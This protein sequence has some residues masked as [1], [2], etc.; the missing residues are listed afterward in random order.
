MEHFRIDVLV[1]LLKYVVTSSSTFDFL[2]SLSL[3]LSLYVSLTHTPTHTDQRQQVS[4]LDYESVILTICAV[5]DRA[6][7]AVYNTAT[8]KS[9]L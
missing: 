4:K 7:G 9:D 6:I 1:L 3:P 5:S 2:M 8:I